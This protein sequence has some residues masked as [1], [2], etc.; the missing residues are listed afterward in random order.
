MV[1][2]KRIYDL[3]SGLNM[4][5]TN[6]LK[7]KYYFKFPDRLT[8]NYCMVLAIHYYKQNVKFFP[9]SWRESDQTSNVKLMS[10]AFNVLGMLGKYALHHKYIISEFRDKPIKK[11]TYKE[12]KRAQK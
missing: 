12:I 10:Q 9:I 6:S 1:V 7:S 8:F 5:K 3:G 11:Y 2:H 4:Y